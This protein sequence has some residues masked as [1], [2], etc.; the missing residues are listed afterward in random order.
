[1]LDVSRW[2]EMALG[3]LAAG[4]ALLPLRASCMPTALVKPLPN[5]SRAVRHTLPGAEQ[6]TAPRLGTRLGMRSAQHAQTLTQ[7]APLAALATAASL[8][9]VLTQCCRLERSK[10]KLAAT[11]NAVLM[12]V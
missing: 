1:M 4:L 10:G 5:P 9:T 2:L 11:S 12:F 3:L 6:Q 7:M 8:L